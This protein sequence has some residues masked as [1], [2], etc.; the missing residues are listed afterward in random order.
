VTA[1]DAQGFEGF[2]GFTM[3]RSGMEIERPAFKLKRTI[4][5]LVNRP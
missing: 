1:D 4:P 3:T 2:I 5:P